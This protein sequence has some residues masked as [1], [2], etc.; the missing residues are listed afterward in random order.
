MDFPLQDIDPKKLAL[1]DALKEYHHTA[2]GIYFVG[3]CPEDPD[4]RRD[5]VDDEIEGDGEEYSFEGA[6]YLV[7]TDDEA[8]AKWDEA[9]ENYIDECILPEIPSQ[10]RNYFD[11]KKWKEDA[12][13]DGRGHSL[14]RYD[15]HEQEETVD[16]ETF[17]I[18]RTN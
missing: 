4:D 8:D 3:H 12:K 5:T 9:L 18:Y 13:D 11:N 7:L 10:Y 2:D 16:G 17:Y 6:E 14:A 1:L 15:G